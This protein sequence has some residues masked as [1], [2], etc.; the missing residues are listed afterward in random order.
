MPQRWGRR[1]DPRVGMLAVEGN[2]V[3]RARDPAGRRAAPPSGQ[4]AGRRHGP[5]L[6]CRIAG[7]IQPVVATPLSGGVF[8]GRRP[9][10]AAAAAGRP[11]MRSP[12][13]PPVA[14]R[15]HRQRFWAATC[16]APQSEDQAD[17]YVRRGPVGTQRSGGTI[18]GKISKAATRPARHQTRAAKPCARHNR[19]AA[20]ACPPASRAHSAGCSPSP[21]RRHACRRSH[22]SP[23][24]P[25]SRY[26]GSRAR[27]L[28]LGRRRN[29]RERFQQPPPPR[30]VKSQ[31]HWQRWQAT[32]A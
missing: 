15:E 4:A 1:A 21:S 2:R 3:R 14:R 18:N 31:Y 32:T 19:P 23:N 16:Q 22:T 8:V 12:G 10:W 13:R 24:L 7:R 26:S 17:R 28:T 25:A 20:S 27:L 5:S 29:R 6:G 9:G 30:Q 11:A